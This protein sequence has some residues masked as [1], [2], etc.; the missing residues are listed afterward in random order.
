MVTL[1]HATQ[2]L[3][4]REFHL[5]PTVVSDVT[6]PTVTCPATQTYNL[7]A[8]ECFALLPA[9]NEAFVEDNCGDVTVAQSPSA[10]A[11]F[12]IGTHSVSLTATDGAGNTASCNFDYIVADVT[13]PQITCPA[14]TIAAA[15]ENCQAE[16]PDFTTKA[17]ATDTCQAVTLT[18]DSDA[19]T[20]MELGSYT[21]TVTAIDVSGNTQ[22]CQVLFEVVD[23]QA[24]SLVCPASQVALITSGCQAAVPDFG[25]TVAPDNCP[26]TVVVT[27]YHIKHVCD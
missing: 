27:Q 19:L 16:L 25:S 13:S 11:N 1:Q 18:Q 5:D 6:V 22:G 26:G 20:L 3:V 21:V 4:S 15:D 24:P 8:F 23:Q 14:T 10:G 7:G 12:T 9:E 17:I 2:S